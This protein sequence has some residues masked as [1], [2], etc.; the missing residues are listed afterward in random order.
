MSGRISAE[1]GNNGQGNEDDRW[2][3]DPTVKYAR[4]FI[5]EFRHFGC[6]RIPSLYWI[7]LGAGQCH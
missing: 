2:D 5:Q 3:R 7:A 1:F 4:P 6:H